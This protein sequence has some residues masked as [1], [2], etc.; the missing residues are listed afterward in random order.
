MNHNEIIQLVRD[1]TSLKNSILQLN[2]YLLLNMESD[3]Y[4]KISILLINKTKQ[5]NNIIEKLN[6]IG[7]MVSE[8]E[9][10]VNIIL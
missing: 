3:T 4:S 10:T 2:D 5:I 6:K 8:Y 1:L 9:K 7:Y